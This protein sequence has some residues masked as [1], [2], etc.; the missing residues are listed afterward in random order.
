MPP[1]DL[2]RAIVPSSDPLNGA[3]SETLTPAS[4]TGAM[5][6]NVVPSAWTSLKTAE[7]WNPAG[8]PTLVDQAGLLLVGPLAGFS[9]TAPG[10]APRAAGAAPASVAHRPSSTSAA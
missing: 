7:P 9:R 8:Q 4:T 1:T 6:V 2:T 3:E 10:S 5:V